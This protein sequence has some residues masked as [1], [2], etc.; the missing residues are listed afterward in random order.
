[1]RAILAGLAL[2]VF[3]MSCATAP[4][5]TAQT[6][7]QDA[8]VV[9]SPAQ[10]T[11]TIPALEHP[12]G[13]YAI[14]PSHAS[15]VWRVRHMGLSMYTGRFNAIA[16]TLNLNAAQPQLST[17]NVT[18]QAT[19]V[20]TG[21]RNA[22]GEAAF[23]QTIANRVFGAQ[24]NPEITFVSTRIT[25]AD[26]VT[27]Q[28]EGNLTLNGVTRPVTLD[29]TFNGGRLVLITQKYTLGFS[30]RGTIHR[31]EFGADAWSTAVGDEVE[32]VI[33]AEFHRQS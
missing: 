26:G 14:D 5:A 16:A 31:S 30:A 6:P 17:L 13:T 7:T 12:S 27:G 24:A 19:S 1:M 18:L 23:D 15:V 2:S 10:A 3:A 9:A 32:I 28:V 4:V 20:D 11:G 29:V 22:Q 21:N 8:A 33:E 25:S